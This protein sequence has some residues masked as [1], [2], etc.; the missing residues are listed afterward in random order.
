MKQSTKEEVTQVLMDMLYQEYLR[1]NR[2]ESEEN[3]Q[4]IGAALSEKHI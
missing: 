4:R 3:L 1:R 2:E